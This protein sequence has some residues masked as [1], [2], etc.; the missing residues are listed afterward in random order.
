M[1]SGC[2]KKLKVQIVYVISIWKPLKPSVWTQNA[3]CVYVL[4]VHCLD[5]TQLSHKGHHIKKEAD[6]L[7]SVDDI[8]SNITNLIIT[9]KKREENITEDDFIQGRI[10]SILDERKQSIV[11]DV[12]SFIEVS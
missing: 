10:T 11:N 8:H 4:N 7:K 5:P 9:I 1:T 2:T 12:V 3:K 6:F